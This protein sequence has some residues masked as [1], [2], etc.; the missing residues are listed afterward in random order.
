[1]KRFYKFLMPMVAMVAMALPWTANAQLTLTVADGTSTNGYVPVYGYYA[2]AYLQADFV[3]PADSLSVMTGSIINSMTFFSINSSV[4]WGTANFVVSI[5]EVDAATLTGFASNDD[6]TEVY[7]G[8]LSIPADGQMVV[9]FT[10]PYLYTGSNLLVRVQ[11]TATGT[12]VSSTWLG[13]SATGSSYQGYDYSSLSSITGSARNFLPKVE[14]DYAPSGTDI[15]F[16]VRNVT[17]SDI[18]SDGFTLSWI[19]TLNSGA[20]Y[21]IYDMTDTT[22][23]A[24]A[25]TTS[26]TFSGLNSNT[27]YHYAV[28]ADCGTSTTS[29]ARIDVRTLCGGYATIPYIEDFESSATGEMPSCWLQVSTGTSSAGAFPAVY[30]YSDN[31]RTGNGYF[32]FESANGGQTEIAAL[33][34]MQNLSGLKLI[35]W[36]S[37]SSNYPC[38]LEAGVIESDGTFTLVDTIDLITFSGTSNW[39]QNYHEYTVYYANYTGSGERMALRASNTSGQYT[40]FVD[41]LIVA[42]DNGCY[43]VTNVSTTAVDSNSITLVWTDDMNNGISYTV[44]YWTAGGDTVVAPSISDTTYTATELSSNTLYNFMITPNC[45]VGDGIPAVAQFRTECGGTPVPFTE[46]FDA[47]PAGVPNCWDVISGNPRVYSSSYSAHSGS[48]LLYFAGGSPNTIALP[49]MSQPTGELQVRFWTRP[50]NFTSASCGTF[51]VGYMTDITVDSTF[52]VVASWEY[53]DFTGYEEVEVPMIGAPANARIVMRQTNNATYYY[54]YVDDLVVEPIPECARPVSVNVTNV[55]STEADLAIVGVDGA[56]YRVWWTDGTTTDSIDISTLSHTLTGL[57]SNTSYTVNVATVCDDGS[58]T[59]PRSTTLHTLAGEAISLFPYTCGFEIAA[60]GVD[61]ASDWVIDNGSYTNGWYVDSAVNNGGARALYVSNDN[62]TSNAYTVTSASDVVAYAVFQ[63]DSVEYTFSFDWKGQGESNYDYLKVALVPASAE[64]TA[65][66]SSLPTGSHEFANILNQ[67]T[68]WQTDTYVYRVP[69]AGTYKMVFLWHNDNSLG[70]NPPAAVDNIS[71]VATTCPAPYAIVV[72]TIEPFAATIHWTAGGEETAWNIYVNDSVITGVTT[73]PYTISGLEQYTY[74]NIAVKG[75]CGIGDTS[76][77]SSSITIRTTIACPWPTNLTATVAGDTATLSWNN[78]GS[79]AN[80]YYLVYG[81]NG[82]DP[83]SVS[84]SDYIMVTDTT[85]EITGLTTGLYQ[86][87]V[88]SDCGTFTSNWTGPVSFGVGYMNIDQVDTLY[89]CGVIIS[90]DGGPS[91]SYDINR[92]DQVVIYPVDDAHGLLVSG[93]SQTEGNYDYLTIYE[94]AGTTGTILF[95]D[96]TSGDTSDHLFGPFSVAGPVTIAFHSDNSVVYPGFDVIVSCFDISCPMPANLAVTGTDSA[97]ISVEWSGITSS[98]Q[99]TIS[100]GT[101]S[102]TVTTTDTSYTFTGL[103]PST[104]YTISVAAICADGTTTPATSISAHTTCSGGGCDLVI[105]ML[106]SYGDGWNGNAINVYVN[107]VLTASATITSGSSDTYTYGMCSTDSISLYW[108][109]GNYAYE[110]SFDI[111]VGGVVLVSDDGDSYDDG[112]LIISFSG[113][114]SCITPT[115]MAV[116]G[117][118]SSSANISWTPSGDET[119]WEV[120]LNGTSTLVSTPSYNATGLSSTTNY[121]VRV[122]AVCGV[123]DTSFAASVSFTTNICDNASIVVNY[124]T[125]ATATTSS[126]S[127]IGYSLYNYSYVQTIIPASRLASIGGDIT[128]MAFNTASTA[129]GD[130]FTNMTVY[131]ANV[132]E[133]SLS[134][135]F[136]LPDSAHTFVMVIDSANFNYTTTGWQMHAFDNPFAWD[137]SSNILVAVKRDNGSWTSGSSFVAHTDIAQRM[138]YAYQDSGPIDISTGT[139]SSTGSSSTVGDIQLISCGDACFAP[140][141]TSVT[142]TDAT[143]DLRWNGNA[144]GYEVAIVAGTWSAP[145]SGT[146][147]TGNTYTFTGLTH[148]TEYAVGV[149]AVCDEGAYSDW[150]VRTVTTLEHP[151]YAPTAVTASNITMDG[152]TISWTPAEADQTQFE[153]FLT[154]A[155]DTVWAEATGTSYT[156]T[157]LLNNT[158]YTVA[159][160]AIC[161]ASNYSDWSTSATFHTAACQMVEGVRASATT[162]TTATITWTANGSSSYEVAY[163]IT[164]TSRENCTRLTANTNSITINGLTE[165][166]TYDVYVRSVCSEGVTSDWS[167]VVTFETQDVAIDDV[168]NASIS[169]YPNP[170][171]STVTL[172]GIE[173]DATVTVVDMNGREVYTQAIKQSSNQTITIDVTGYAQGAYFVRITGE[174]VNAIRKLIVR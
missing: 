147:V 32:E 99:L 50:E 127:P 53:S 57:T 138:R 121:T 142:P 19:D 128:A 151:C 9:T 96:N 145:A 17:A 35:F 92:N 149:R 122:R 89:T 135:G 87:Y 152:A 105:D 73:N 67:Q 4:D 74:Y 6:F 27:L 162:A 23:V 54:W 38:T 77:A 93:H 64:V 94:G 169:L 70:T 15:C 10:T 86:A 97:E 76:L 114:P 22:L 172:T 75:I 139:A 123:G 48:M 115:N 3:Y 56:S 133:D 1:M 20:S 63:L 109:E 26:Y 13:I 33:P 153:L 62:G 28:V 117:I 66:S 49:I 154:T 107:G 79:G 125:T 168:D 130:M 7:S 173:G 156:A 84:S 69:V 80:T 46:N 160:R 36:A 100:D 60:D 106:D 72:D 31:T 110:T 59:A 40:L 163:G 143:I 47:L 165:A 108:E 30:V 140:V 137:G 118:T 136:I 55:S 167:D 58:V 124:D 68:T 39:K 101:T 88:R 83:S 155:G 11:N 171:S 82:F 14:F 98:Y 170:A 42:E 146:P 37:M 29:Y 174:R 166:T 43:P 25:S 18:T 148:I 102:S 126:Y 78:G 132:S 81:A 41:D 159:V 113:C 157:G 134:A 24:S 65:G 90:D 91:A 144:T 103:N 119:Q 61:E 21:S 120:S 5:K 158:D 131:M 141:V 12:Y 51:E 16:P 71:I 2:D 161:G 44:S 111:S 34:A 164:G 116:S 52:V 150:T 95:Q 8:S 129:A 85:Y 112:D 104:G 45:T